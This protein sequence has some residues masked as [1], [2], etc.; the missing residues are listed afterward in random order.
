[1]YSVVRKD[2]ISTQYLRGF[3]ALAVVY[4]HMFSNRIME[5]LGR[6]SFGL[7]GVDIFFVISGFVMWMTTENSVK[8]P[9]S[10]KARRVYRIYPMYWVALIIWVTSRYI[11]PDQ[12]NNKDVSISSLFQSALLIPHYHL[13][14]KNMIFPILIPGWTLQFEM[15]FYFLFFLCLF[16]KNVNLR[17]YGLS[18]VILSLV[19]LGSLYRGADARAIVYTSPLLLEFLAGVWIASRLSQVKTTPKTPAI[20]VIMLALVTLIVPEQSNTPDF[21]RFIMMGLPS[22]AIF[23]CFTSTEQYLSKYPIRFMMLL[24]D[25]SFSLYLIH[26]IEIGVIAVLWHK[27]VGGGGSIFESMMFAIVG[28]AGSIAAAII[29]F[30]YVEKPILSLRKKTATPRVAAYA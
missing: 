1:M 5:N 26:S 15:F 29:L 24:G 16:I 2:V 11:F 21:R 23:Y 18:A 12:F 3:A 30:Y 7:W 14:F 6:Y 13:V 9:K 27:A 10:F 17:L 4:D 8:D 20:T 28:I 25:I 22:I 19:A